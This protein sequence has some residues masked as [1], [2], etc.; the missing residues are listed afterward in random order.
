VRRRQWPGLL[1]YVLPAAIVLVGVLVP[2]LYLFVRALQGE[3]AQM[4][5]MVLRARNGWLLLNTAGLAAGVLVLG[6]VIAF[7]LAWLTTRSD[8]PA[9]GLVTL[10]AVLPLAIPGYVMAYALLAAA[11]GLGTLAQ[12]VGLT[13]PRITGYTGALIALTLYTYPYMFLNLRAALRGLDPALEESARSLGYT[14]RRVFWHVTL[15]QLRPAFQTASLLVGLHVLGDFGVVSLMRFK[16]FSYALYLEYSAALGQDGRMYVA[17]LALIMLALTAG[18]LFVEA[19]M[20]RGLLL[21]RIGSGAPRMRRPTKL[22]WWALPA[23]G[24]LAALV[25]VALV[26]PLSTIGYWMQHSAGRDWAALGVE[27]WEALSGSLLAS[28]PAA[29]VATVL[30][31]PL[32]YRSVRRPTWGSRLL[33]RIAY[34]GYATPPLVFALATITF[35]LM[36]ARG[37]DNASGWVEANLPGVVASWLSP[38]LHGVGWTCIALY[39]S[40]A[41]LVV[42]YAMHFL[43]EAIGPM[44][45]ALYQVPPRMEETARSLSL[46][47]VRT[48]FRVTLPLIRAGL[49]TA[50]LLVFLSA[51]KELPLTLMLR[52]ADFHT[53]A[54]NVWDKTGEAMFA[55]AAPHALALTL[56]SALFVAVLLWQERG[57]VGAA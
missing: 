34:F 41:L 18:V 8:M 21:H 46:G 35:V 6:T 37:L 36:N 56:V 14:P 29:L 30:A 20:L 47:P 51:M 27:L 25:T 22:G 40:L 38:A 52:P 17:W 12:T 44:R 49:L 45:S 16:T 5:D 39:Q 10:L 23:W 11:G 24:Y 42:A 2:L 43:A 48:F 55:A 28:A 13:V 15:P 53:L 4:I 9:K 1:G 33:E 7:P 3:T 50:V 57:G 31:L 32:V 54:T 19:R 26:I